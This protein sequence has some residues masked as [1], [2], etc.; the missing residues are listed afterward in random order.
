MKVVPNYDLPSNI[1]DRINDT[2]MRLQLNHSD[3]IKARS[4]YYDEYIAH[5]DP[6][7]FR[8]LKKWNPFVAMELERQGLRRDND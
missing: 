5:D 8:L 4:N 1:K 6:L 2:I 3:C 7:P